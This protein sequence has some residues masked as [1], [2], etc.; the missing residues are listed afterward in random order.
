MVADRREW[1]RSPE[2]TEPEA[3]DP[4]RRARERLAQAVASLEDAVD[5]ATVSG[6]ERSRE[7]DAARA[8]A[9]ALRATREQ[10]AERLDGAISRLRGLLGE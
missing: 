10:L 7:L 1:E 6:Q 9:A 5:H 4:V 2:P 8:E 3:T